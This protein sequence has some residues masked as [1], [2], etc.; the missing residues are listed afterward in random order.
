MGCVNIGVAIKMNFEDVKDRDQRSVY[1]D[2]VVMSEGRD[3][4]VLSHIKFFLQHG[5][6][7]KICCSVSY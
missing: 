5:K 2:L 3:S 7:L 6:S 1:R 4:F